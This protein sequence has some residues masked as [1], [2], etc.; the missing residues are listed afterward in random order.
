MTIK[1]W[2]VCITKIHGMFGDAMTYF[3]W[4][5]CGTKPIDKILSSEADSR[6]AGI[7]FPVYYG[8]RLCKTYLVYKTV[9]LHRAHNL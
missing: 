3:T 8:T 9:P 6:S 5:Y 4:I 7:K 2:E 1:N